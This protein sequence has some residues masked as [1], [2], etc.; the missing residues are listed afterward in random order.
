M[1]FS[2]VLLAGGESRR[3][4]RDKATL[5]F[6]G[7]P[8]WSRQLRLLRQ[9]GPREILIS[10]RSDP[11]WRPADTIFIP[12][13]P[14]SHGPLS[15]IVAAVDAMNGTHLLVLAVDMPLMNAET[16]RSMS[17][18]IGFARGVVPKIRPRAEPLAAIYPRECLPRL[19]AA[20]NSD[21]FSMQN[22]VDYLVRFR[23]LSIVDVTPGQERLFRSLNVPSDLSDEFEKSSDFSGSLSNSRGGRLFNN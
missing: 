20:L 3:M 13:Q 4:G 1:S 6:L 22:L 7:E 23:L 10:A 19:R 9:I 15:G 14:P 5:N 21:N 16:L 2:A 17:E 11:A 18:N 8:L 12:D